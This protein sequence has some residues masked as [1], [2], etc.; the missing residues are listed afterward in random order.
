[1]WSSVSHVSEALPAGRGLPFSLNLWIKGSPLGQP[2]EEPPAEPI[3]IFMSRAPSC[4]E[5]RYTAAKAPLLSLPAIY[6]GWKACR[7]AASAWIS[8]RTPYSVGSLAVACVEPTIAAIARR[9][10]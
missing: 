9:S 3:A 7:C 1:M 2:Q 4:S 6:S 10:A 5:P 8:E